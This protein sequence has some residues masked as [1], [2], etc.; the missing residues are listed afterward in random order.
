MTRAAATVLPAHL[1]FPGGAARQDSWG[2]LLAVTAGG[3][4]LVTASRLAKGE[5]VLVGFELGGERLLLP[6]R[7]HDA[8]PDD[9]GHCV[10]ELRWT[11]MV[12]RKRL[13]RVL[14][15]VLARS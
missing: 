2:R 15:D 8:A 14:A 10:A 3:A 13:A 6:G 5:S 4:R 12:E 9:D 7:V 1:R 11:D